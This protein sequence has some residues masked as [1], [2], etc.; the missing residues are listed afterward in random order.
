MKFC[1]ILKIKKKT[2]LVIVISI[3]IVAVGLVSYL[4][5]DNYNHNQVYN[6]LSRYCDIENQ[7]LLLLKSVTESDNR[8][9]VDLEFLIQD[10]EWEGFV[11]EETIDVLEWDNPYNDYAESIPVYMRVEYKDWLIFFRKVDKVT[12]SLAENSDAL[13]LS[14]AK[15]FVGIDDTEVR[16]PDRDLVSID[17]YQIVDT[18]LL[19]NFDLEMVYLTD[20]S[21]DKYQIDDEK[22]VLFFTFVIEN[23]PVRLQFVTESFLLDAI[24]TQEGYWSKEI[25]VTNIEE[26]KEGQNYGVTIT[27]DSDDFEVNSLIENPIYHTSNYIE[28]PNLNIM[29]ITIHNVYEE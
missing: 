15:Y 4:F 24:P 2:L 25:T 29:Y 21:L 6:K 23:K 11:L 1:P 13:L 8:V 14:D 9:I 7:C 10:K 5:F 18:S 16:I 27:Y 17:G 12:L 26:I 22:I 20:A 19:E 3:I 28:E